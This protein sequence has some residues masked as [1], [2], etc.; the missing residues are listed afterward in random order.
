MVEGLGLEVCGLGFKVLRCRVRGFDFGVRGLRNW[1]LF[2][3]IGLR[4]RVPQ[5]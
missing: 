2:V 1:G 4:A 5:P 3:E